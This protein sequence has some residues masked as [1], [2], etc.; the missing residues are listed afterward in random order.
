MAVSRWLQA[1][2][3]FVAHPCCAVSDL[4]DCLQMPVRHYDV[5]CRVLEIHGGFV[6][7]ALRAIPR[8]LGTLSSALDCGS[9]SV[10]TACGRVLV[11]K[12]CPVAAV[13]TCSG[14][15]EGMYPICNADEERPD[16]AAFGVHRTWSHLSQPAWAVAL[17]Q[18]PS[19]AGCGKR[20]PFPNRWERTS[21]PWKDACV[22]SSWPR[23]REKPGEKE[24]QA[25]E[26]HFFR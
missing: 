19:R 23:E 2:C 18:H 1:A 6:A 9:H 16:A 22:L 5:T 7:A 8:V 26:P 21:W 3:S 4:Q 15:A 14:H 10:L 13:L 11:V 20:R 24:T 25:H 17:G 12:A